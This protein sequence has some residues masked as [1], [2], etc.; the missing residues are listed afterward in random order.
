M[1]FVDRVLV[2]LA[3]PAMQGGVFDDVALEQVASAA[4]DTSRATIEG[5]YRAV[6]DEV[7]LGLTVQRSGNAEGQ[8]GPL[9]VAERSGANFVISGL[10][11]EGFLVNALWKGYVVA[12]A[13]APMAH[14]AHTQVGYV[15]LPSI[16]AAIAAALG[17]L[18][19]DRAVLA[20]ERRTRFEAAIK[21]AAAHP[22]SVT[23]NVMDREIARAG[24]GDINEYFERSGKT[25]AV[26]P[27]QIQYS[28]AAAPPPA[29]KSL[30]ISAAI[31]IRNSA[32]GLTQLLADCRMVR[33]QLTNA[34]EGRAADGAIP[35][36]Y[37]LIAIWM[38]PS[39]TFNDGD[40]P[41][42]DVAARREAAGAWLAR[43]G[44]GLAVAD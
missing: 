16:D 34:G 24:A 29:P 14:I 6:F 26:L 44:V 10:G 13:T 8:F 3:D 23:A 5:P 37:P 39:A 38:L 15:D 36:R 21:A 11:G 41:G 35:Q 28:A 2:K 32:T 27:V 30:P 7:R 25:R 17:E 4:Y 12:T 18:P 40:W 33:E 43:E 19:S 20:S 22:S 1:D 42:A 9:G 31:V